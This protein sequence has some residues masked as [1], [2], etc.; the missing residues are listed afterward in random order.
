MQGWWQHEGFR[1]HYCHTTPLYP[2]LVPKVRCTIESNGISLGS[3]ETGL[4]NAF[5]PKSNND[6]EIV[7]IL[8]SGLMGD[9]FVRHIQQGEISA[10]NIQVLMVFEVPQEILQ[11]IGHDD[12]SIL[13]RRARSYECTAV[14][15]VGP[16]VLT[17][18]LVGP[19]VAKQLFIAVPG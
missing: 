2:L 18:Q 3:G 4:I 6:V 5:L 19:P 1:V 15:I 14:V 13:G 16:G 11:M 7:A 17:R 10:F 8:N 12:L 9:W